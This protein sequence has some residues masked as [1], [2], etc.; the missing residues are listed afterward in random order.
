MTLGPEDR[1]AAEALDAR[2]PLAFAR[3]RFS[4]PEGVVYL[5]GNSLGA[6]PSGVRAA[7]L[8]AVD[9]Q[10]GQDLIGSWNG[11]GWWTL[12]E[13]VGDRIGALVGA[14]P[15]Q[16][17]CGD[18][19]SVQLFQAL[20]A[21]ARLRP[22]R[23]VLLTDA[24]NF[25]TDQYLAD[26]VARLLGLEARRVD[27]AALEVGPDVAVV[28]LSA[29][30]YRTGE[31]WDVEEITRKA[32]AAGAVVVWDLCHAAGALPVDLDGL[33]ADAAV[34]C[35]YKY[36]NGG[37]GA[38]AWLYLPRRH[39][40]AADLPLTGWTGRADPFGLAGAYEP[41]EG[42]ARARIGTPPVLSMVAV[43]AALD[44]WDGVDLA[45][46]R[47]KSLALGDLLITMADGLREYGLTVVTPRA[48][49]RR[50]SQVSLRHEKAYELGQ[51]LITRGV[52][53]DFRAPDLL[54]LGLAPLYLRYVDVWDAMHALAGILAA[55][56]HE[57]PRYRRD[58]TAVVT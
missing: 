46:V 7:V 30:D 58:Q 44:V 6:L 17:I 39:Q 37:P 42:V 22:D 16:T 25:P 48:G 32:H 34:G 40:Q 2:D 26:A 23:R 1:T 36:L 11:N 55:N 19:T 41:A 56:E 21:A 38:P 14:A 45:A 31:L 10:W 9:R 52:V 43:E 18:S 57:A 20:T 28:A 49:A 47:A 8:D 13:R 54:R 53:G 50:G 51:A 24:A 33:G 3:G 29:V 5:D 4:V 15:G 35:T 12:P 27:P